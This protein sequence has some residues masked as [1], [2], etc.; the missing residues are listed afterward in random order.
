MGK[1]F[2][3]EEKSVIYN[4]LI[5]I[6]LE[7]ISKYGFKK[8]SIEDIAS[9]AA[10]SKGAFYKFF[11]SKEVFFFKIFEAA[12]LEM[13]QKAQNIIPKFDENFRENF[14]V[15]LCNYLLLLKDERYTKIFTCEDIDYITRGIPAEELETHLQKDNLDILDI[16]NEMDN[17]I[18]IKKI[19]VE[20]IAGL[21]KV[22]FLTTVHQQ[23][24]GGI[25]IVKKILKSQVEIIADHLLKYKK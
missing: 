9:K 17:F 18:D 2:T 10:I 19:D 3:E 16:V 24:I 13:K 12:E 5:N 25:E 1:P 8:T 21:T 6:G 11:P 7:E 20:F 4:N 23:Q 14:V 15:N 22:M